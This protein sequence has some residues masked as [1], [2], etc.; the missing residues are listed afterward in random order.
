MTVLDALLVVQEA[1]LN[2][3]GSVSMHYNGL[4]LRYNNGP[5]WGHASYEY[6]P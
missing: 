5:L 6:V 2:V 4:K 1:T 3:D